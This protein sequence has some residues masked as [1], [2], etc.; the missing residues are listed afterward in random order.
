MSSSSPS[1]SSSLSTLSQQW[2][3]YTWSDDENDDNNTF[4]F[5]TDTFKQFWSDYLNIFLAIAIPSF[6]LIG[7]M[8]GFMTYQRYK[9]RSILARSDQIIAIITAINKNDDYDNDDDDNK[10]VLTAQMVSDRTLS[11]S[12][13]SGDDIN[14]DD[15]DNK[16]VVT[17]TTMVSDRTLSI[18]IPSG[19]DIN[20]DTND[21]EL[22]LSS[23]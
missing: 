13:P 19:D 6:I 10:S 2:D 15:V 21:D 4:L 9:S 7:C 1:S 3:Q 16:S 20:N 14:N 11:I 22:S 18:S 5:N 23:V 8:I 12:I 17:A